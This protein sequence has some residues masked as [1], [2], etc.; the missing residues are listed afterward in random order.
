VFGGKEEEFGKEMEA[1]GK[2]VEAEAMKIC[3]RLPALLES[4]QALAAALP[5]FQ[6]Y[7]TMDQS[8]V[9]DCGKDGNYTANFGGTPAHHDDAP[10]DAGAGH[11]TDA[12]AE[13]DAAAARPGN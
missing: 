6:P 11:E 9:E 8:D 10:H 1:R 7:A 2:R 5:A 4:Q 12:A 3:A 13:A